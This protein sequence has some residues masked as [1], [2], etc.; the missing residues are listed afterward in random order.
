MK[1]CPYCAEKIQ[2]AAIVCRYCGRD[3]P[4]AEPV[5]VPASSDA[6]P[7]YEKLFEALRT[8]DDKARR[9]YPLQID[10]RASVVA[11]IVARIV[12]ESFPTDG[13]SPA[14]P[15]LD[16]Y[17]TWWRRSMLPKIAAETNKEWREAAARLLGIHE[18]A[19]GF[20]SEDE[21]LT[22]V[23]YIWVKAA[24][25]G[26]QQNP[27]MPPIDY[28]RLWK[29]F[30]NVDQLGRV[31]RGFWVAGAAMNIAKALSPNKLPKIGTLDWHVCRHAYAQLEATM[32]L[33]GS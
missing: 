32:V 5:S 13:R 29:G 28:V 2:D 33:E 8:M 4:A 15:A 27:L 17:E 3:L 14:W 31:L 25:L 20:P 19:Q 9:N 10:R 1:I 11:K 26:Y 30:Q 6:R 23:A 7:A 12:H 22:S 21:W 16:K 18:G 24:K